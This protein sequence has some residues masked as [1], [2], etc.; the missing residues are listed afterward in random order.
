MSDHILVEREP[1]LLT[2]RAL[3]IPGRQVMA[4]RLINLT[5]K[6]SR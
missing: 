1:G 2:L 5:L 3:E 6:N 4:V